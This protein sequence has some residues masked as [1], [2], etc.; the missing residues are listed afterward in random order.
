MNVSVII[1]TYHDWERLKQCISSLNQQSYPQDKFEVI[2]VNNDPDDSPPELSLQDNFRIISEGKPGSYAARNAGI[3]E[4]K[5]DILAFTDSDCIVDSM[6]IKNATKTLNDGAERVAGQVQLFY[7]DEELTFVE[8]HE[9]AFAFRQ[10]INA[11]N[12]LSIT[13]NMFT[14][15]TNF[16]KIGLFNESMYSGGDMEWNLRALKYGLNIKYAKD[17]IVK[18]PSRNSLNELLKKKRRV[19]SGSTDLK[20]P[21]GII[22]TLIW[23]IK[24]V[25][26]PVFAWS[27]IKDR[28]D[29]TLNEKLWAINLQYLLK[30]YSTYKKVLYMAE[31]EKKV[32]N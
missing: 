17:V 8:K 15:K 24:G 16:D 3:K 10:E 31:I 28:T 19:I 14:W 7:K 2:I 30:M 32:R 26:P 25:M 1:P 12:G 9:K 23:V 29:L 6:W 18:H 22:N 4:A 5:G 21:K 13:A 20:G 11:E 27:R